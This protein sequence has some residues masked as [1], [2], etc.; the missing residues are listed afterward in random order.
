MLG[1][2][3][4]TVFRAVLFVVLLVVAAAIGAYAYVTHR[5]H[6]ETFD[7][8]GVSLHY[9]DEGTGEPVVLLHGYGVNADLNWRLP[10]LTRALAR[11]HRVIALDL[12]GHGLSDKPAD[13]AQY[14]R[15]M[16]EDIRRLLDH[17]GLEKVHLVGYSLGGYLT[18]KFAVTYPE[19][20]LTAAP[21]GAGWEPPQTPNFLEA[22][23]GLARAVKSGEPIDP[24]QAIFGD[25]QVRLNLIQILWNKLATAYLSDNDALAALLESLPG[26]RLTREDLAG[27][28]VPVL[29][30]VGDRDPLR[31][32]AQALV[33][34]VPDHQLVLV[35]KSD[36]VRTPIRDKTREALLDFLR[37]HPTRP[38][39]EN[40]R[41]E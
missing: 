41:A 6:G 22:M 38:A 35:E 20:L 27:I 3:R 1:K 23:A 30:I 15:E 40:G 17:L 8:G 13:P 29:S 4:R 33:G 9:T 26:L 5:V 34:V 18:L 14:G 28:P 31:I 11:E 36:H 32:S 24:L 19:R 2:I 12:R 25:E 39:T 16:V 37:R 7:S 21:L 10:G